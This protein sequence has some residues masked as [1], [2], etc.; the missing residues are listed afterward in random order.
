MLGANGY[1]LKNITAPQLSTVISM[2][3]SGAAWLDPGI[4]NRVLSAYS[5]NAT[6]QASPAVPTAQT[7][8]PAAK[9]KSSL[10]LSPR[11]TEGVTTGGRWFEQS[12]N[13]RTPWIG[14]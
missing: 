11:E 6:S 14:T 5:G 12:E 9:S 4:A 10:S 1:C 3:A 7:P 8:T 2:V 13:C